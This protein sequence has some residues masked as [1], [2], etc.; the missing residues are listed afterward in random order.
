MLRGEVE[1]Q[2]KQLSGIQAQKKQV[3]KDLASVRED[4]R[5]TK[6]TMLIIW[7]SL[8]YTYIRI[9]VS[10]VYIMYIQKSLEDCKEKLSKQQESSQTLQK[11]LEE[12]QV[13]RFEEHLCVSMLIM[14]CWSSFLVN[15]VF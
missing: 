13:R 15:E 5:Q 2:K 4:C 7:Y 6:V 11:Q 9:P 8:T 12:K 3:D 1:T 14:T 10:C